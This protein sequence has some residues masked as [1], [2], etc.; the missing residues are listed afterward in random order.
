MDCVII[1]CH[2]ERSEGSVFSAGGGFALGEKIK[3]DSSVAMLPQNDKKEIAPQSRV[4]C[5]KVTINRRKN[6]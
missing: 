3:P 6:S 1:G 4:S 2:P 5:I